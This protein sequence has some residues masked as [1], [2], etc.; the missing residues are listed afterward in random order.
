MIYLV[1]HGESEHNAAFAKNANTTITTDELGSLLT[2][3]GKKQVRNLIDN[4]HKIVFVAVYSSDLHR[5][6]DTALLFARD[7]NLDVEVDPRLRERHWG[8]VEMGNYAVVKEAMR[9][10]QDKAPDDI[11]K[12][13]VKIDESMESEW[14]GAMRV[15]RVLEEIHVMHP[16][17]NVLVVSHGNVMR[18]VLMLLGFANYRELV[19]GSIKNCGYAILDK[20]RGKW[21][22]VKT[23]GIEKKI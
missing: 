21:E 12:M 4:L 1:R 11:T 18:N 13:K 22:I 19:A 16:L 8:K 23:E 6:H 17:R 7:R 9:T 3:K 20:S 15:L 2:Q 10:L 14:E 5:A